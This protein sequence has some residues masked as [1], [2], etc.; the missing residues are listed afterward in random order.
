MRISGAAFDERRAQGELRIALIGMSNIGK[1]YTAKRIAKANDFACYDVDAAI[2][3]EMGM[4]DMDAMAA[5]MGHPYSDGYA[6]KAAK[7]LALES[8]LSLRANTHGKNLVLDT[9]GSVIHIP[10]ADLTTLKNKFII[11]YIKASE[12]DMDKLIERYFKY[13]KPTIWGDH[14][15]KLPGKSGKQSLLACYPNLLKARAQLYA[16]LADITIDA[17]DFAA[18]DLA[19]TDIVPLIR[20]HLV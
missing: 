2:Q 4:V 8:Y 6:D 9:T 14:F 17:A 20:A 1:S 15:R 5:W 13:P 3:A 7:Y 19:D 18:P 10:D 16:A 12:A 11:I